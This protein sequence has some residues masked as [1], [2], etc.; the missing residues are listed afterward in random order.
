MEIESKKRLLENPM[1]MRQLKE[2]VSNYYYS[3]LLIIILI[4]IYFFLFLI[5][6]FHKD[7]MKVKKMKIENISVE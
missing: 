5:C 3:L 4:V 6:R 2:L 1:K 7:L